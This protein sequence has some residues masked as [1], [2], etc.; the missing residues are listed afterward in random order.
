MGA[1][2]EYDVTLKPPTGIVI[3]A[4]AGPPA[5]SS[6]EPPMIVL[7]CST[8]AVRA[9]E[10]APPSE[11]GLA[12]GIVAILANRSSTFLPPYFCMKATPFS[13]GANAPSSRLPPWQLAQFW[14]YA[15]LP[16]AA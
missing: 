15:V 10:V 7:A 8:Y 4:S 6:L 5:G 2:G 13:A 9:A 16:V 14:S 12:G 3:T 1:Y 11:L